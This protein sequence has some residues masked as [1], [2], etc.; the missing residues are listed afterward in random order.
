MENIL[1]SS[2]KIEKF[3]LPEVKDK[4]EEYLNCGINKSINNISNKIESIQ[5]ESIICEY[6]INIIK[7]KEISNKIIDN[8]SYFISK[9]SKRYIINSIENSGS[10]LLSVILKDENTIET[11]LNGKI[12]VFIDKNL[13]KLTEFAIYKI[14]ILLIDNENFIKDNIKVKIGESLNFFEK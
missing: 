13:F 4:L 3:I 7:N 2:H 11:I 14:K 9:N 8:I 1:E 5:M 12:K 10:K 6:I